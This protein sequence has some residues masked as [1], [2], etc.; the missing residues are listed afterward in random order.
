M[1]V[2][3]ESGPGARAVKPEWVD[4]ILRQ[5]PR[6]NIAFFFKH[7]GGTRKSVTG[8]ELNGRTYDELPMMF[9]GNG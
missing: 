7:W 1:I 3:G 6:V 2:G 5:C 9:A 8:P 4:L